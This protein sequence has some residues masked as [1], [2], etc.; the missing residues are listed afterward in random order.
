LNALKSITLIIP[1]LN[2]LGGIERVFAEFLIFLS[3]TGREVNVICEQIDPDL[4]IH[5]KKIFF[6]EQK[7]KGFKYFPL[8]KTLS[9]TNRVTRLIQ[10]SELNETI[11]IAP[12]GAGPWQ[13]DFAFAGSCHLAALLAATN[14]T[15]WRWVFN[16]F[17]YLIIFM[18]WRAFKFGSRK[19][20]VPSE[21][22]ALEIQKLYGIKESKII[23]L[24]HGVD[25]TLFFPASP[26]EKIDAK[27]A[28]GIAKDELVL[29]TVT[30][31][32][33]RKGCFLVLE[34]IEK[35]LL[36]GIQVRYVIVGRDD[37]SQIR[38]YANELSI[39]NL[40]VFLP[41]SSNQRLVRIF[42][43]A[44]IFLLPTTYES[45]GL[46]GIEAMSCGVP[47]IATQVG[48]IEDY[49]A[50]GKQGYFVE[51]T[52]D[53]IAKKIMVLARN[54][55]LRKEMGAAARVQAE[56]YS[57]PSVLSRLDKLINDEKF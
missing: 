27:E 47:L 21:R 29:L 19:I 15:Q 8:I 49:L 10:S 35:L 31:E 32:I 7:T 41:P 44:D 57:W 6:L 36:Q 28:L 17:H 52:A 39:S 34:A 43:A 16:P 3:R 40:V 45:F 20:L 13:M 5:C 53:D 25:T 51:R 2:F 11:T 18:E 24:P 33:L 56:Q 37:Y 55:N 42:H 46:V 23:V 22:T 38:A 4:K 30:N 26:H 54:L 1:R 14:Q 12:P 9:W 50:D 48:G